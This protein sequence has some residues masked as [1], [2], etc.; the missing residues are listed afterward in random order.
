MDPLSILSKGRA[1]LNA[2]KEAGA[3]AHAEAA[4]SRAAA[5]A[6]YAKRLANTN[7]R[8]KQGA[9]DLGLYHPIGGGN[10]LSK[11][12]DALHAT[13]VPDP[14]FVQ[15]H[16]PIIT[17]EQMVREG[18]AL[19]PLVGDRAASGKYLTH[20]GEKQF[21]RPVRLTG[22]P[23]YMDANVN[24]DNSELS[25]AWE[26]GTGVV[27]KIDNAVDLAKQG[28]VL[29]ERPVYGMYTAGSGTNTDF[30]K[31]GTNAVLQQLPY[32]KI[33]KKGAKEFDSI[34][35]NVQPNWPGIRSDELE[36]ILGQSGDMR[37]AFMEEGAKAGAQK[38]GLPDIA[39]TR[40]AIIEPELL[41]APVGETGF[42]V[43]RMGAD[44]RI[45][46]NPNIRSDYPLAMQ[47]EL[48]GTMPD[49]HSYRDM[50]STNN[51]ARRLLGKPESPN[52]YRSFSLSTP[53]QYADEEW[54]NKLRE[55]HHLRDMKIKLGSY[56]EGGTVDK[57]GHSFEEDLAAAFAEVIAEHNP[58]PM[59][60]EVTVKTSAPVKMAKGG[61]A[62]RN[63]D[64]LIPMDRHSG[65]S[66]GTAREPTLDELQTMNPIKYGEQGLEEPLLSPDMLIGTGL[67]TKAAKA[68]GKFVAP[69]ANRMLESH[70]VKSG[71]RPSVIKDTGGNWLHGSVEEHLSP[72]RQ[73]VRGA[74]PADRLARYKKM[75]DHPKVSEEGR[76]MIKRDIDSATKEDALDKWVGGNL[77]NYIKKQMGTADDPVRKLAEQGVVH[78]KPPYPDSIVNS[79]AGK[80]ARAGTE[81]M[82]VSPEAQEWENIADYLIDPSTVADQGA[83]HRLFAKR[84]A[85]RDPNAFPEPWMAKADPK[86]KVYGMED[87]ANPRTLGFD[88]IL[89]V[90]R[91]DIASGKLRPEQLNKVSMEQAVRRTYEFDQEMAE[92]M[93]NTQLKNTEGMPIHKEY[94]DKGYK[95]QELALNKQLPEGWVEEES[96]AFVNINGERSII[97]PNREALQ[98]ALNYEGDVMGHCVGDYCD[99]VVAGKKRIFS[100]RDPKGES[101]VTIETRP[102][103]SALGGKEGYSFATIRNYPEL[104]QKFKDSPMDQYNGW[105]DFLKKEAPDLLSNELKDN[106]QFIQQMKAKQNRTEYGDYLPYV[107]DFIKSDPYTSVGDFTHTGLRKV[108]DKYLTEAEHAELLANE[109]KPEGMAR[110]G[111]IRRNIHELQPLY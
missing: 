91:T 20:V 42:R 89:D 88:H 75:L 30:N 36:A 33:S 96:G 13:H 2:I 55:A 11:S 60:G 51:E 97:H 105:N 81:Q 9:I 1:G 74:T 101:H 62:R 43:A 18:A 34:M 92:R 8:S 107:Q 77:T 7:K 35:K 29:G 72:L 3:L 45:I 12:V 17:P 85:P 4:A 44:R 76:L 84:A 103:K 111:A 87:T 6:A 21:D 71:M 70:M 26:S 25:A 90:L 40:K 86:T 14:E 19:V 57:H 99:D 31:M 58:K 37:K 80:R 73:T 67:A 39:H 50:F 68:V 94:P 32:S 95:W 110:G 10:K 98:E 59:H 66:H 54:L 64:E 53:I 102:T 61:A 47:G 106:P 46:E 56:K 48:A 28:N 82:G 63:V 52:D 27:S 5:D 108:G 23:R 16:V 100:L 93:R 83:I 78:Y 41:D 104:V 69:T 24:P 15:P 109:L 22:G 49:R 65:M 38:L 79:T